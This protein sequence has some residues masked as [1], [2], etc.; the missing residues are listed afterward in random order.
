M[1]GGSVC[2][3]EEKPGAVKEVREDGALSALSPQLPPAPGLPVVAV[4]K[5][6]ALNM[7]LKGLLAK[8]PG[9]KTTSVL[10][11]L[12]RCPLPQLRRL[13]G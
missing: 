5:T 2:E 1:F 3:A 6:R 8:S 7:G 4:T 12:F 13:P 11:E 9:F 10:R